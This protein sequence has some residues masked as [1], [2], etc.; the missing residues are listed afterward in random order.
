MGAAGEMAARKLPRAQPRQ[1]NLAAPMKMNEPAPV[2][3]WC[4]SKVLSSEPVL[5]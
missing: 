4:H 3:L 2:S 1:G 5:C